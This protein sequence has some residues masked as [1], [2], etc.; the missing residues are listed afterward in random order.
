MLNFYLNFQRKE[1]SEDYSCIYYDAI[2][3][4]DLEIPD[5]QL[6]QIQ[7]KE[8]NKRMAEVD[9]S[10]LFVCEKDD[11]IAIDDKTNFPEAEKVENIVTDLAVLQSSEKGIEIAAIKGEILV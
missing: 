4:K 7:V 6:N 1:G 5:V 11:K 10:N 8:L 3:R 9:W 2:L